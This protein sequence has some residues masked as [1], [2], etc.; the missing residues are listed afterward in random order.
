M[1]LYICRYLIADCVEIIELLFTKPFKKV[2]FPSIYE[3]DRLRV[4]RK[5][6]YPSNFSMALKR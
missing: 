1:Y 3:S 2:L 4:D 5:D 6:K